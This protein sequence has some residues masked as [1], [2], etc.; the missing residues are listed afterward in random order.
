MSQI[1]E[2]YPSKS[3]IPTYKEIIDNIKDSFN[4]HTAL[5]GI[6]KLCLSVSD[7]NGNEIINTN[8]IITNEDNYVIFNINNVGEL[9][10]FHHSM[11][12]IDYEFWIDEMNNNKN[13]KKIQ[14]KIIRNLENG[15]FWSIKKTMS[16]PRIAQ[17][18]QIMIAVSISKHTNGYLYSDDGAIDDSI[19]P[20]IGTDL[21]SKINMK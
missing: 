18:L 1:I 17:I 13:A 14:D 9:Y 20:I 5:Y 7:K 4:E 11:E 3:Y 6:N 10:L 21:L 19:V 12:K 2:I 15:Y 16:Q 8:E